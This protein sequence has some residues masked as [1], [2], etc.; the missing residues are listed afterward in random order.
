MRN[1]MFSTIVAVAVSLSVYSVPVQAKSL[2]HQLIKL[3]DKQLTKEGHGEHI[4]QANAQQMQFISLSIEELRDNTGLIYLAGVVKPAD[5]E[6]YLKQLKTLLSTEYEAYRAA[7]KKRDHGQF[8]ITIVNPFEYEKLN[9]NEVTV[10]ASKQ[11]LTFKLQGLGAVKNGHGAT[12]F[13][14]AQSKQAQ[15]FRHQLSLKNKD[16]HVTL[17]FYPQDI[18]GVR[19]NEQTIIK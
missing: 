18:Y 11:H 16:F 8:H 4:A 19:K 7:Q 13:V 2:A 15:E 10:L 14:V 6:I 1:V 3:S 9:K 17:G 12:Y 5:I